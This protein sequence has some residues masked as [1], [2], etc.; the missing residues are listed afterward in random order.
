MRIDSHVSFWV[1]D[2]KKSF[3]VGEE[4]FLQ[5]NFLPD[6]SVFPLNL[7]GMDGCVAVQNENSDEETLFL[8][9]LAQ[10]H[11]FVSGVI[12]WINLWA[13][14]A[15]SRMRL[16]RDSK[17]I[18][19]FRH[20]FSLSDRESIL[21]GAFRKHAALL[22]TYGFTFHVQLFADLIRPLTRFILSAPYQTFVL[23]H[24]PI[25]QLDCEEVYD[26]WFM[27]LDK[28]ARHKHVYFDIS[29]LLTQ[30]IQEQWPRDKF[31]M[32]FC[33]VSEC[34]GKDKILFGSNF[35]YNNNKVT[36][37]QQI[38]YFEQVVKGL[39]VQQH[40]WFWADNPANCFR[41]DR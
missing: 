9:A 3:W 37:P 32:F 35:P 30:A 31:T 36:Y 29:N 28:I 19:G 33:F 34:F 14:D 27:C 15:E 24:Q 20:H 16:F 13:D 8:C 5:R 17:V 7:C 18:K 23:E 4:E 2:K 26:T 11:P 41:L 38:H 12:A 21:Q 25:A 10:K 6:P 40:D 1:Y 22:H 39:F